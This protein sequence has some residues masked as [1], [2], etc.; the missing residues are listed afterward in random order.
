MSFELTKEQTNIR[1]AARSLCK[2]AIIT[3]LDNI[4]P[5]HYAII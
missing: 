4:P 3:G 1:K 5:I 2:S